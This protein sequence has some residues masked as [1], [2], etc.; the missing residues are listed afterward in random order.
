[1]NVNLN[2]GQLVSQVVTIVTQ[3]VGL[4]TVMLELDRLDRR[5]GDE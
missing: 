5:R 3:I 2:F 4:H 1:M